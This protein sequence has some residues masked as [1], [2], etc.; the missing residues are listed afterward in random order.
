LGQHAA[1]IR[2]LGA[3]ILAIAVTPTFAQQA[4][5]AT[6]AIDFPLLSDWNRTVSRDYGCQYETWKGHDGLAKRALF[7]I[8]ADGI[9]RYRWSDDDAMVLPDLA[10]VLSALRQL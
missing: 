2:A 7:V 10:P 5:A 1:E 3:D 9:V 6:L 8:D 4:F